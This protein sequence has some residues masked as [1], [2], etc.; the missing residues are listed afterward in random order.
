M[1]APVTA[2]TKADLTC[3]GVVVPSL[4]EMMGL[5][6]SVPGKVLGRRHKG[7]GGLGVL[8]S[9][10]QTTSKSAAAGHISRLTHSVIQ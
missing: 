10:G 9:A 4:A 6:Q 8:K 7:G 1:S 2:A 5:L 3:S